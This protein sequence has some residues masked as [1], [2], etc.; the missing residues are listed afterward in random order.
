ME[1]ISGVTAAPAPTPTEGG[2]RQTGD[3]MRKRTILLGLV[4]V[5]VA[6]GV[7]R[8]WSTAP[9][10]DRSVGLSSTGE[11]GAEGI[12]ESVT[13]GEPIDPDDVP[14]D[15]VEEE[16]AHGV[17][18]ASETLVDEGDNGGPSAGDEGSAAPENITESPV[19]RAAESETT[20][21][22]DGAD[23]EE[24]RTEE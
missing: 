21:E 19:D 3:I 24:S 14:A 10:A 5:G 4:L 22:G 23:D 9:L 1:A 16:I 12:G 20:D 6:I 2:Y 11:G 15:V 8:K 18:E 17:D 7:Y 13:D